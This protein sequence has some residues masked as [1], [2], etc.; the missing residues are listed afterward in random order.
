VRRE[1]GKLV[2][3]VLRAGQVVDGRLEAVQVA[4][5][6]RPAAG[7][8]DPVAG[9]EVGLSGVLDAGPGP[10]GAVLDEAGNGRSSIATNRC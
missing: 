6:V 7:Q 8:V 2:V 9:A 3:R 1:V 5:W 4:G 10:G